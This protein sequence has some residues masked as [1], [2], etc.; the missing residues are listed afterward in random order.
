M[1]YLNK[2]IILRFF[3]NIIYTTGLE[4]V[5][6]LFFNIQPCIISAIDGGLASQMWQFA[7]GYAASKRAGIPL[8]LD[9]TWFHFSGKDINGIKNRHFLLLST[10][11]KVAKYI[12]DRL[13]TIDKIDK[14]YK[15]L[16]SDNTTSRELFDYIPKYPPKHSAYLKQYYC[17]VRYISKYQ[18][19]LVELFSFTP[20]LTPYEAELF[21][22]IKNT[23]SCALHIRKGDFVGSIH[24][25]CTDFYYQKA[26]STIK[27]I[28]PN[29]HVFVFSNDEAWAQL[30]IE[31]NHYNSFCTI[32]KNRSEHT[33][34]N[35][36]WLM[37]QCRHAIISN[38]GFSFMA[39]FLTYNKEKI[40]ITPKHWL[41]DSNG[42][43]REDSIGAYL[44]DRWLVIDNTLS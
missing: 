34:A 37:M 12:G 1:H 21:E 40:V 22:E 20:Q 11:P 36:L 3:R 28:R 16:Y 7:L 30:F 15:R 35:D 4:R 18:Q 43:F 10:F 39:A 25:V 14:N 24:D 33:P 41:K 29:V 19:E 8:F 17:N 38:S 32:I 42:K 13:T 23:I 6:R 44:M 2:K 27:E 31:R 9:I 26:I 5:L